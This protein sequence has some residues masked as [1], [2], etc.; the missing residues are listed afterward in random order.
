MS[1]GKSIINFFVGPYDVGIKDD[2][3]NEFLSGS[4]V[5]CKDKEHQADTSNSKGKQ[6]HYAMTVWVGHSMP[7]LL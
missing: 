3:I 7:V 2:L 5:E 1:G 4:E 6:E